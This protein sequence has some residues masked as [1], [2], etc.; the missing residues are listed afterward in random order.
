[1]EAGSLFALLVAA[2]LYML[3][4]L[5][6]RA[7][8]GVAGTWLELQGGVVVLKTRRLNRLVEDVGKKYKRLMGLVGDLGVVTGIALGAYGVFFLHD[9]LFKLL[10]ASPG[11]SPVSPLVPGVTVGLNELAYFLLAV[12]VTLI[13]H[14]LSHAFQ[15]AAEGVRIKSMGVF[16]A[17]LVPGGFAEI[18]EDELDSKPLRSKL[19][20]LAAGSFANIATFL[21]LVALFYLVLFTPLAPRPNGVLVSGVIQGSPAFQRLQPGDVIVA[22]NGTPTPTLEGFSKVMERSA[23]GRLIKLTVM[24]GSVL[25]NYSLVL[26]QHPE[27]PGRGFIGVKI[28]QSYSNEWLYR[29]FWWM[30]VV[31]SS[32][33]IINMLPIVPLDGGK[34]LSYLLQAVAPGRASK[35]AV[36]AC[37]AYMLIVLL[38]SMATSAGVFGLAPLTP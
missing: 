33:A 1:M 9:N 32:V 38:A 11:A 28:D 34:L 36:W 5:V 8:S 4:Y 18:D 3:V 17:F 2:G 22:V 25:V 15:A 7:R 31:T 21:L 14:E 26:A 16:L 29:A 6:L 20:V 35:V 27:S 13:P 23:P 10:T 19:R 37:S 30:L 24:R 12:A